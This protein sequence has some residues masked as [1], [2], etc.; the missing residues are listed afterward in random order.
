LLFGLSIHEAFVLTEL[1]NI[2]LSDESPL[3]DLFEQIQYADVSVKQDISKA[4]TNMA[5]CGFS[6]IPTLMEM[7]KI[8]GRPEAFYAVL[9]RRKFNS[10]VFN[11][12]ERK[13]QIMMFSHESSRIFLETPI[14]HRTL[15]EFIR[16]Q[17][18]KTAD[19]GS[20]F[21]L[22]LSLREFLAFSA[23][24]ALSRTT[25]DNEVENLLGEASFSRTDLTKELRGGKYDAKIFASVAFGASPDI[26]TIIE[27]V[28]EIN[29]AIDSLIQKNALKSQISNGKESLTINEAIADVFSIMSFAESATT[30][31]SIHYD[32]GK[33]ETR[34]VLLYRSLEEIVS[35]QIL[36]KDVKESTVIITR[37]YGSDIQAKL[38]SILFS[39][40][41]K[42]HSKSQLKEKE[43]LKRGNSFLQSGDHGNALSYF[44]QV[45]EINPHNSDVWYWLGVSYHRMNLLFDA[46]R[47][48][49]KAVEIN[50]DNTKAWFD[51]GTTHY[52]M[53]KYPEA[54]K[55]FSK[56]T[57]INPQPPDAWFW[58]GLSYGNYGD[59]ASAHN[60]LTKAAQ[61]N[62]EDPQI[63]YSL[64]QA[65]VEILNQS[66]NKKETKKMA[67]DIL[68]YFKN[69]EEK[70]LKKILS[71][72]AY[73]QLTIQIKQL[74]LV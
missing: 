17:I 23:A 52:Q 45:L 15:Q 58:A 28:S 2:Q 11:F 50:S 60:Y 41:N 4:K 66:R 32:R 73:N 44:R 61:R 27:D 70:G 37:L 24:S 9:I 69:A 14:D 36:K 40:E 63:W 54:A 8:A 71:E 39:Q 19:V 13:G 47:C 65:S 72:D 34:A 55:C 5:Q 29:C 10:H 56:I 20:P 3:K 35:L 21:Q 38:Q 51:L 22:T 33:S 46:I 31:S 42:K 16:D 6:K 1:F 67:K 18:G 26:T 7:M 49:E 53:K 57:E 68:Q 25:S 12:L 64:G 30:V 43:L 48:Y 62:P 59:F 74:F